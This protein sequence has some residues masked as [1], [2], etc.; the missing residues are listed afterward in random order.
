ME[1]LVH[2]INAIANRDRDPSYALAI[3]GLA[4]KPLQRQ[5]KA[6]RRRYSLLNSTREIIKLCIRLKLP[7]SFISH[8]NQAVSTL[9][10]LQQKLVQDTIN[11]ISSL[12]LDHLDTEFLKVEQK[13]SKVLPPG[14][15]LPDSPASKSYTNKGEDSNIETH[16][17]ALANDTAALTLSRRGEHHSQIISIRIHPLFWTDTLDKASKELCRTCLDGTHQHTPILLTQDATPLPERSVDPTG[18]F[19]IRQLST[20][21]HMIDHTGKH[22][23]IDPSL[24][25]T[26]SL[27]LGFVPNSR[28]YPTDSL[29]KS[30]QDFAHKLKWKYFWELKQSG[31][32]APLNPPKLDLPPLKLRSRLAAAQAPKIQKL[33]DLVNLA[34]Q[35]VLTLLA[36]PQKEANPS[37]VTPKHVHNLTHFF[38]SHGD[39]LLIKP[40]D[41]GGAIVILHC[42]FYRSKM[43]QMLDESATFFQ[44]IP[45]DPIPTLLTGV[46]SALSSLRG[47]SHL[48]KKTFDMISP[49]PSKSR[50]PFL[51]GLPKIH[52]LLVAFRP[53]ISG[54]GHPTELSS[55]LVDYLLQPFST[56]N[57]FYLKD[58]TQLLNIISHLEKVCPFLSTGSHEVLLFNLDVVGMYTNIPLDEACRAADDCI[59]EHP[60]LLIHGSLKYSAKLVKVLLRLILFNNFFKFDGTFYHQTH[61]IAMGTPCACTVSDIFICKFMDKAIR[62]YPLKPVVY[63]QYRDD[64]FG[65]WT[66]GAQELD[67]FLTYLNTLHKTIKFTL[68]HGRTI[69]YLDVRLTLDS[70]NKVRSETFYKD[71]ETFDY[72]HPQSNHPAHCKQ[73]I[74]LSQKIRHIRNCTTH[75][76]FKHHT[77][78]LKY[79]LIKRGYK[80]S[81]INRKMS[82]HSFSE[83]PRLL[84]YKQRAPLGRTPLIVPFDHSLPNLNKVMSHSL[85]ETDL[86]PL[87]LKLLGGRPLIGYTIGDSLGQNLIRAEF[88]NKK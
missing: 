57:G 48:N 45:I 39:K 71:T 69:D 38:R 36:R 18:L 37:P 32:P 67:K 52:K 70:F 34:H 84:Q 66:H 20:N 51:Y 10:T 46:A 54:N 50:C 25:T 15:S 23:P 80:L 42:D 19:S 83:R 13:L 74:A 78:L 56:S 60:E 53:I 79:N 40:A 81:L 58:T 17:A 68:N 77:L 73:N 6:L 72:L 55:I 27:G 35:R 31:K 1:P 62:D 47:S 85:A 3:T 44:E 75:G 86:S 21:I 64:G 14:W 61:G 87:D 29:Q 33:D 22:T 2:L 63:K 65:I 12:Y 59:D 11:K 49:D 7:P 4:T 30:F 5:V 28:S 26:L 76:A 9:G 43:K 82:L 88:P 16:I 24:I 41:K 8:N